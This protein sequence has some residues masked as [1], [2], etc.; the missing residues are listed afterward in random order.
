V[1]QSLSLFPLRPR[2]FLSLYIGEFVNC[3]KMYNQ[4][5]PERNTLSTRTSSSHAKIRITCNLELLHSQVV[6]YNFY[7]V[8]DSAALPMVVGP[9]TVF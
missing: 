8:H 1:I 6:L 7:K 2:C 9:P 3:R 4:E 5:I